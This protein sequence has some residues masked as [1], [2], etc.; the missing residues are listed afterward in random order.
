MTRCEIP[1]TI[2]LHFSLYLPK[3]CLP[4]VDKEKAL[5]SGRDK[6]LQITERKQD[7]VVQGYFDGNVV[8]LLEKLVAKPNQRVIITVTDEFLDS[9]KAPRKRS[10]RGVLSRYADVRLTAKEKGAWARATVEKYGS[11]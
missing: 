6:G 8:R 5:I 2:I 7:M 10:M 11:V 4:C 9:D 3:L 1:D